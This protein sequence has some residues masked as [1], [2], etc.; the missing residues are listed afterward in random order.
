MGFVDDN[1]TLAAEKVD[2]RPIPPNS[3]ATKFI[4]AANWNEFRQA[5]IDIQSYLRTVVANVR[6]H[7]AAGDGTTDDTSAIQDALDT[8]RFVFFPPGSYLTSG[9]TLTA[10]GQIVFGTGAQLILAD[11][12]YASV[13]SADGLDRVGVR[14]LDFDGNSA[15]NPLDS[16]AYT[17]DGVT[18]S[19]QNRAVV[20]LDSCT[21]SS[22]ERCMVKDA[23]SSPFVLT[24]CE[25]S[26]IVQC[27]SKNHMREGI[28]IQG[29]SYCSIERCR[30]FYDGTGAVVALPWSL[31]FTRGVDNET[32]DH[33][34]KILDNVGINSQAAYFTI[35]TKN[36]E[37]HGN[38]SI[39]TLGTS[40]GPGIRLGHIDDGVNNSTRAWNCSVKNNVVVGMDDSPDG[41]GISCENATGTVVADN[42]VRDCWVGLNVSVTASQSVTLKHNFV[43]NTGFRGIASTSQDG[44]V[45]VDN[46]VDT[47]TSTESST[48]G[49]GVFLQG[50][51]YILARNTVKNA[52]KYGYRVKSGGSVTLSNNTIVDNVLKGD[53]STLGYD[54]DSRANH[55]IRDNVGDDYSNYIRRVTTLPTASATERGNVARTEGGT[56]VADAVYV[57]VKLDDD[58]YDWVEIGAGGGITN[59]AGANVIM[60]SDGT[61]AVASSWTDDGTTATTTAELVVAN[62]LAKF[63]GTVDGGVYVAGGV[64]NN[65]SIGFEYGTNGTATGYINRWGYN[66]STSQFR[67]LSIRDGK[68]G[69]VVEIT[70][71]TKQVT[72]RGPVLIQ[73]DVGFFDGSPVAKPTVSGSRGGNAA[74]ASLLTALAA[75]GLITDNTTA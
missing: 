21:N 46:V 73:G 19:A 4:S 29:G 71:S 23:H 28:G 11:A 40:K 14:D 10:D 12:A 70:G 16:G 60:K 52:S 39:K 26:H 65:N 34:H 58:T 2:R 63:G 50:A 53:P 41:V 64:S 24:S 68:N 48:P 36:T 49:T 67:N 47:V 74:L 45:I 42:I 55:R 44:T 20:L 15:G 66:G 3:S 7:G 31:Y 8:G 27:V 57:C 33:R 5:L 17:N 18:V 35:N 13:L 22:I 43:Y 75:L 51:N 38:T 56:G 61:D 30:S 62:D 72:F 37:V 1:T 69:G 54:L 25:R 6:N 59:G 32:S 9:N